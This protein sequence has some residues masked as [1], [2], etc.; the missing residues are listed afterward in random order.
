MKTTIWSYIFQIHRKNKA[1]YIG[2]PVLILMF[3]SSFT[4]GFC[5]FQDKVTRNVLDNGITCLA[6]ENQKIDV[7]AICV[8]LKLGQ[9]DEDDMTAGYVNLIKELFWKDSSVYENGYEYEFE[10]IGSMVKTSGNTDYIKLTVLK[11]KQ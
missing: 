9:R 3:L 4:I 7:V 5:A 1:V 8:Y 6:V 11:N 2:I 10:K